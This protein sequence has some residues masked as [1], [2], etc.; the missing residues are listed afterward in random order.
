MNSSSVLKAYHWLSKNFLPVFEWYFS[1]RLAAEK[2][3]RILTAV[4]R[5]IQKNHQMLRQTEAKLQQLRE[6]LALGEQL[7]ASRRS[8][9]ATSLHLDVFRAESLKAKLW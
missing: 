1:D 6:E 4:E 7:A 8:L 2:D 9:A 3:C 5:Q